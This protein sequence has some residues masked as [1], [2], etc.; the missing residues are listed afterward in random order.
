MDQWRWA[1]AAVLTII[2][3]A[4]A[5]AG[6]CPVSPPERQEAAS[7]FRQVLA[8]RHPR[9]ANCHG[10]MN[11]YEEN[12]A[13]PGGAMVDV[14]TDVFGET[15][16]IPLGAESCV[17]C[18]NMANGLWVQRANPTSEIQWAGLSD[19]ELWLRLQTTRIISDAATR[20]S[21]PSTGSLLLSHVEHDALIDFAF[22]GNRAMDGD[23]YVASF[24]LPDIDPPPLSKAEF[25]GY[26]RDWIAALGA[27]DSWPQE[28][29]S[30][31]LDEPAAV[32]E[33]PTGIAG[34]TF[35]PGINRMGGD[36]RSFWLP[37]ADPVLCQR[38]C[39]AEEQCRAWTY[40]VP[41]HQGPDAKCWLKAAVP[42]PSPSD[43]CTSGVSAHEAVK[44][45][46]ARGGW[47]S[48]PPQVITAQESS[49]FGT[50]HSEWLWNGTFYEA[51]WNNGTISEF[52]IES[53][54]GSSLVANRRDTGG[55]SEGLVGRYEGIVTGNSVAG[56]CDWTFSGWSNPNNSGEWS[57]SW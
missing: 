25:T 27:E 41:G 21:E 23:S 33:P 49:I 9:C 11:V 42:D 44:A 26:L 19:R 24:G 13:H 2:V 50:Y 56:K 55:P 36:Y 18:H 20:T 15:Q 38:Q 6:E 32:D 7:A 5:D 40:V 46:A 3:A 8:L 14:E 31:V 12:T 51:R 35:E 43:C 57:A 34:G 30:V 45:A 17:M 48:P 37:Q 53:F 4:P 47:P 54:D 52:R 10:A 28:D 22:R 39:E 29:C 1:F 16:T